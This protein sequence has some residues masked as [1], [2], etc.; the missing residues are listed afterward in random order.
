MNNTNQTNFTAM[1]A[2]RNTATETAATPDVAPTPETTTAPAKPIKQ[3]TKTTE[4]SVAFIIDFAAKPTTSRED[5]AW[6]TTNVARY[7]QKHKGGS[8]LKAF[9]PVFAKKFMPELLAK[10]KAKKDD[11]TLVKLYAIEQAKPAA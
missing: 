11:D 2:A 10:N 9:A 7:Q 8:W 1:L 4:I 6:I 5:A 3:P